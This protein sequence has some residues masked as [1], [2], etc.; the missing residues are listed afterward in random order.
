MAVFN[1]PVRVIIHIYSAQ[2]R[3]LRLTDIL[4]KLLI[5]CPGYFLAGFTDAVAGGGGLISLPV[6]MLAGIPIHT[7][8]GTNKFA[9][10]IG[11][12]TSVVKYGRSGAIKWKAALTA[13]A[14][15]LVGSAFG[16]RLAL[17]LSERY[18]NMVLMVL[19]P[20]AAV[21]LSLNRGFGAEGQEKSLTP[22]KFAA[23]ALLIGLCVG[24]Y[25]GFFGPGSGTFYIMLFCSL[26]G[27]DLI[28]AS[29]NAK[30][31]NLASNI[32]ALVTFVLAGKVWFA[33]GIPCALCAMLGNYVGSSLA[34][35]NGARFIRPIMAAVIML[36]FIKVISQLFF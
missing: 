33:V 7:V 13:A 2:R 12:A 25:D 6:A 10:S 19:L 34:V 8:Y 4:Q 27:Y 32:G 15:A 18:L 9:M 26:M 22:L 36:L 3:E 30:V 5:V 29:G 17:L 11:T 20:A 24:L 31:V 23:Y 35:K 1:P 14:G 16:A 21:F 28:T